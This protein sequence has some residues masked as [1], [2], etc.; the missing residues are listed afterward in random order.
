MGIANKV[1]LLRILLVPVLIFFLEIVCPYQHI[2]ATLIF[3]VIAMTDSLDGYIARKRNEVTLLG[4]VMDPIADK[5]IIS[6]ALIFLIG[7]GVPAWMAFVIITREFLVSGLRILAI[8]KGIV[9][10]ASSLGKVKTISLVIA[11]AAVI[12]RADIFLLRWFGFNTHEVLGLDITGSLMALAVFFTLYSGIDY[13]LE[14]KG[15]GLF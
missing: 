1:T 13:F 14:A 11:I 12:L 10:P 2:I 7:K 5:V 6:A 15:K 9:I 4:K 8:S 3:L